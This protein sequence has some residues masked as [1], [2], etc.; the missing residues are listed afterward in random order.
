MK[1]IFLYALVFVFLMPVS[2]LGLE[3]KR[4]TIRFGE[5]DFTYET[6]NG[7]VHITSQNT[8]CQRIS[9]RFHFP[10]AVDKRLR[11]PRCHNGVHHDLN[12]AAGGIFHTHR[13]PEA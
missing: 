5:G 12:V 13:D 1:H 4:Y 10:A 9:L 3:D 6:I 7:L 2:A 11:R 8:V